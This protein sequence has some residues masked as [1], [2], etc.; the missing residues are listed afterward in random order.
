MVA[1][2]KLVCI[3]L[4]V[5]YYSFAR[6]SKLR[7]GFELTQDIGVASSLNFISCFSLSNPVIENLDAINDIIEIGE[8]NCNSIA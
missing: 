1:Q 6:E 4:G 2:F 7:Y 5:S 3:I 8:S